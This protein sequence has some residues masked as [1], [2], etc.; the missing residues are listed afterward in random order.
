[1]KNCQ[2][3][4]QGKCF[5]FSGPVMKIGRLRDS[6]VVGQN[7]IGKIVGVFCFLLLL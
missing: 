4:E 2:F 1:M 3:L 7:L 5:H 6:H